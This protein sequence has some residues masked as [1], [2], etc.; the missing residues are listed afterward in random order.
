MRDGVYRDM[1]VAMVE[2]GAMVWKKRW[3][4]GLVGW[5]GG[6]YGNLDDCCTG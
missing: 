5:C 4:G 3:C 6:V 2:V 1:G